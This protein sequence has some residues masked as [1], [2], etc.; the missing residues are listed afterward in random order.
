M[1]ETPRT[2]HDYDFAIIGG[3]AAGF[4]AGLYAARYLMK[5]IIFE[6]EFGGETATASIIENWPGTKAIDGFDFMVNMKEQ[7]KDLGVEMISE[8]VTTVER[9]GEIFVV[10]SPTKEVRAKSVLL[11]IGA[12]RRKLGLPEEDRLRGKGI[13]YCTTC[14]SPLY[15]G[16]RVAVVG[17]G[18]ASIKGV[19]ILAKY[20]KEIFVLVRGTQLRAEPINQEI[21]R[22]NQESMAL[23]ILYET[24]VA[25]IHGGETLQSLTLSREFQGSKELA[26]DG[27]MVEIGAQPIRELPQS[28]GV[29]LDDKGF[30]KTDGMMRTNVPGITAA[31]DC[32]NLFGHFKQDITA[33]CEGAVAATAAHE[34]VQKLKATA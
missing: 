7:V 1:S 14:D 31:G 26:V 2:T 15:K 28:I 4:S 30:I 16:K 19:N 22:K 21:L 24:E 29:E 20:A 10:K 8:L 17:G 27:L 6:G 23:H 9:D 33:A 12:A 25:A 11:A 34:F 5:T 13:S 18:D 3:G 32:T